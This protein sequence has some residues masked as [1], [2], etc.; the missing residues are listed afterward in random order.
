M[1]NHWQV[2]VFSCVFSSSSSLQSLMHLQERWN[3][4]LEMVSKKCES[5]P[6]MCLRYQQKYRIQ[7][8]RHPSNDCKN[9]EENV[10]QWKLSTSF[11]LLTCLFQCA[12]KNSSCSW[13]FHQICGVKRDPTRVELGISR[14]IYSQVSY[15]VH[16]YW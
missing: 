10:I 2:E 15:E 7:S 8:I 6:I 4:V 16:E 1:T 11:I 9:Q 5:N 13:L 12:G 14:R 3:M